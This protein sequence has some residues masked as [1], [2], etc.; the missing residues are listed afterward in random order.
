MSS[1]S[2]SS[3][4]MSTKS[5][6]TKSIS[7]SLKSSLTKSWTTTTVKSTTTSTTMT[8]TTSTTPTT[9]IKT[10]TTT[11]TTTTTSLLP[12]CHDIPKAVTVTVAQAW[13][14]SNT[15]TA[16]LTPSVITS[17]ID[18]PPRLLATYQRQPIASSAFSDVISACASAAVAAQSNAY[19]DFFI[20]QAYG[21][22]NCLGWNSWIDG[23]DEIHY[24]GDSDAGCAW[25]Y[26][27]ESYHDPI[28]T[29]STCT[30]GPTAIS[31]TVM[32]ASNAQVTASMT[33]LIETISASFDAGYHFSTTLDNS[34][35]VTAAA[36]SCASAVMAQQADSY[37]GFV[38]MNTTIGHGWD[39]WQWSWT[40]LV[41]EGK[42]S[43]GSSYDWE[44]SV[45][46]GC[47]YVYGEARFGN[48]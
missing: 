24:F 47:N 36:S 32:G 10:T 5:S 25:V 7:T 9:T 3:S 41:L 34:L 23:D 46:V 19:A 11:T 30:P 45:P 16:T 28:F 27:E 48:A 21:S 40:C 12:P 13:N 18:Q 15:V 20:G 31:T 17:Q 8:S 1:K 4:T 44:K 29:T 42:Q 22:W 38:L 33:L 35:N 43:N 37:E 39:G 26:H 2:S 14:A 6:T